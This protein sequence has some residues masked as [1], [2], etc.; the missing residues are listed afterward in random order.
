MGITAVEQSRGFFV[1]EGGLQ[2][3]SRAEPK[4]FVTS[5][6]TKIGIDPAITSSQG[7]GLSISCDIK[8]K[9]KSASGN[10]PHSEAESDVG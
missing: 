4:N 7:D 10:P 9:R 2:F 5:S 3:Q 6:R 8:K 1:G